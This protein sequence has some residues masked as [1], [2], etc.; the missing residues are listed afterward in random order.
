MKK[1][2]KLD[3]I[4]YVIIAGVILIAAFAIGV[5]FDVIEIGQYGIHFTF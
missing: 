1:L 4:E 2:N 3:K 5:G